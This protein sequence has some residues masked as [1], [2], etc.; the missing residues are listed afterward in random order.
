MLK[1]EQPKQKRLHFLDF[2]VFIVWK[3]I[4]KIS[5]IPSIH[6]IVYLSSTVY[7]WSQLSNVLFNHNHEPFEWMKLKFNVDVNF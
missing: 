1:L 7:Y 2:I 4:K 5:K 3:R 6:K